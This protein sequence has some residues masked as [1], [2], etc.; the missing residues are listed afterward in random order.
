[1]L[2]ALLYS[3]FGRIIAAAPA[4]DQVPLGDKYWLDCHEADLTSEDFFETA[5]VFVADPSL[6][7]SLLR[8]GI[9]DSIDSEI[10]TRKVTTLAASLKR[11]S[12]SQKAA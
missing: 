10:L 11:V 12:P 1:M 3:Q 5:Y 4:C 8:L 6:Q 2:M 7:T 9:E